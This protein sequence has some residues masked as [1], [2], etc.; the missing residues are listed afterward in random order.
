MWRIDMA[1]DGLTWTKS[2]LQQ[3]IRISDNDIPYIA[4]IKNMLFFKSDKQ[5][6]MLVPQKVLLLVN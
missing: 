6:F 1:L 3:N 4:I 2:L 5:F